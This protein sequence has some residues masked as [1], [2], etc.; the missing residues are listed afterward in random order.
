MEGEGGGLFRFQDLER[1]EVEETTEVYCG[2]EDGGGELLYKQDEK[3][4]TNYD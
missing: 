2:G 4:S 1:R 3:Q